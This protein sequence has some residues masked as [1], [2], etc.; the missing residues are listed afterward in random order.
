[1]N[2]QELSRL[3]LDA[4]NNSLFDAFLLCNPA[5]SRTGNRACGNTEFLRRITQAGAHRNQVLGEKLLLHLGHYGFKR[6]VSGR[7]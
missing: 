4:D 1:M 5:C 7:N 3:L 6:Y 2:P